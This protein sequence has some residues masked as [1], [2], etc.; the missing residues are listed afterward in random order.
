M[1]PKTT[2]MRQMGDVLLA[3]CAKQT[4]LGCPT[5]TCLD[6]FVVAEFFFQNRESHFWKLCLAGSQHRQPAAIGL[7]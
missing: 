5:N 2:D 4:F 3:P 7:R 6:S 1:M